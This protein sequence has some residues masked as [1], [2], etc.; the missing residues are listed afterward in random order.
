MSSVPYRLVNREKK[1]VLFFC[2]FGLGMYPFFLIQIGG[3]D[4]QT[5]DT[6]PQP[7]S[8]QAQ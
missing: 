7:G 8:G 4:R 3:K 1:E 5:V 6:F 2:G